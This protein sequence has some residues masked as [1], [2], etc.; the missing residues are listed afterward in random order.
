M[1]KTRVVTQ[2]CAFWGPHDGQQH[3]GIQISPKP[4]KMA[5]YGHVQASANGSNIELEYII[6]VMIKW[7]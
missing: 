1:A 6:T 5:F 2:G 7:A 4:S 3:F